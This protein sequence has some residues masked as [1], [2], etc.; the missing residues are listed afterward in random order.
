MIPTPLNNPDDAWLAQILAAN[1]LVAMVG[2]SPKP[3]RDSNRVAQYLLDN[4]IRVIP[5]H[6]QAQEIL[7]QRV[8]PDLVS[9][10]EAVD[11][12]DVFRKPDAVGPIAQAAVDK[13][14]KVLW[15]QL[16]IRNDQAAQLAADAGL[17]VVQD[18]C[19]KI[20]HH[21]LVAAK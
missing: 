17:T 9:I 7:G 11:I 16:G 3:D 13:E 4:G 1:P 18:R 21:R 14:A 12:V 2:L 8:Y 20:E 15:M 10:P 19:I 5:V 6:P